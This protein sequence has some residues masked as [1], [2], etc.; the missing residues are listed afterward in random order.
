MANPTYVGDISGDNSVI[1]YEWALTTADPTG[2]GIGQVNYADRTF[3]AWGTWGGATL[4]IEGS[5]D[6]TTW[7]ALSNAGS[8]SRATA[9]ADAAITIVELTRYVRPKLTTVGVGA[10]IT[11]SLAAR[12]ATPMRT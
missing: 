12:R 3:V 5:N 8:A 1:C 2:T 4:T 6:G 11:V 10:T 7:V 9:T